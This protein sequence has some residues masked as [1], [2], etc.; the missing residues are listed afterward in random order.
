MKYLKY[1]LI[2]LFLFVVGCS[3]DSKTLLTIGDSHYSVADFNERFSFT[4]NDDSTAKHKKIDEFVNQMLVFEEA[5][6]LG[7]ENDPVVQAAYET[8]EKDIIWR[9]YYNDEVVKKINIRDSEIRDLY[10]KIVEQY[11]LAQ[12]VVAEESLANYLET[13]LRKG[14]SF[15]DLQ[16][17]SMDTISENGDIGT[18]SVISIPP[19]IMSELKNVKQGDVSN[20]IKFGDYYMLFKVIEHNLAE[21]PTYDEVKENIRQNIWQE[22]VRDA[23][24]KYYNKLMEKAK[25]E[26]NQ[27][28]L[29]ILMKPESLI[30]EEDLDTW[31]VKKYDTAYVYVRTL[32]GAVQYLRSNARID[33]K[34]LIDRELIPDLVYDEAIKIY[35]DKRPSTKGKLENAFRLLVYQKFYSDSVTEKAAVDSSEVVQYYNEHAD[36]YKDRSLS[37]AFSVIRARLRDSRVDSLRTRL[38]AALREKYEPVVN[39]AVVAQLLKEEK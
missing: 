14:A 15:E 32:L 34:Y 38:F 3:F 35:Y 33:P 31:V 36:E 8:N 26:Y 6:S 19:E 20:A 7:Y 16:V 30:T 18:F 5:K 12:I 28:G 1:F 27:K 22:K 37:Q 25:V 10:N 39:E 11:H 21:Q 29:D 17:F 24:E 2:S 4:P 13:E 23:G 9:S